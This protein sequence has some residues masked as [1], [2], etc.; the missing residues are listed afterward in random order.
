M[1]VV[2][3]GRTMWAETS[4]REL[5]KTDV[6]TLYASLKLHR[7]NPENEDLGIWAE[8]TEPV[9]KKCDGMYFIWEQKFT[10]LDPPDDFC[11]CYFWSV[12]FGEENTGLQFAKQHTDIQIASK[13]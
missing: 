7:T 12:G 10:L 4:V 9:K 5:G 6:S 11:G 2:V 8:K 13:Y 1:Q 3:F